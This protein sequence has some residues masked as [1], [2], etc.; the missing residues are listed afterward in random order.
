MSSFEWPPSGNGSGVTSLNG[1][2]GAINIVA[3]T[4]IIVTP[5]GQNITIAASGSS[6]GGVATANLYDPVDTTLPTSAPLVIDG[7]TVTSG[8]NVLFSNLGSGNNKVYQATV[9]GPVVSWAV[10]SPFGGSSTPSNGA[11]IVI[12]QGTSFAN[13][14]GEFNGTTWLY[15]FYVR[16]FNGVN[17]Y[18][19]SSLNI[20]TLS[21]NTTN[22]TVF[23]V[24]YVGSQNI[25]VHYSIIRAGVKEI[26]TIPLTTDGT[27]VAISSEGSFTGT[28]GVT[29]SAVI[30][31]SNLI[32]QYTSTSTGSAGTMSY[33][34]VRWS[35]SAGGPAGPPSYSAGSSSIPAAGSNGNVQFNGSGLL[36]ASSNFNYDYTNN[37]LQLGGLS[38]TILNSNTISD[39]Q[40]SPAPIMSVS[41]TYTAAIVKYS[42]K[43]NGNFRTGRILIATDGT[44]VSTSE[45]YVEEGTTGVVLTSAV[46]GGF[47]NINYTSTSTG[48]SGTFKYSVEEWSA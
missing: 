35:D 39:N 13:Q 22:G 5:S 28:T 15:N 17:Y 7:V 46:S 6:S 31:G 26:G 9:T 23:S 4:G 14:I 42:M 24:G 3:G 10:Q 25:F 43:R 21:D 36:A 37:L 38:I 8:M 48:F 20:S 29:F 18:E 11:L 33:Y 30:S 47:V 44:N 16:Y 40:I 1:E 34:L 12:T 2:T 41:T 45:D 27:N 19:Q 32:L